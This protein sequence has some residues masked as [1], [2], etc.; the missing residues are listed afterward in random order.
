VTEDGQVGRAV[1]E[2]RGRVVGLDEDQRYAR[3]RGRPRLLQPPGVPAQRRPGVADAYL[4][5]RLRNDPLQVADLLEDPPGLGDDPGAGRGQRD[6][7]GGPLQHPG[8]EG[9]L[10]R[11]DRAGHRRLGDPEDGGRVGERTRVDHR[12][13]GPELAHLHIHTLSV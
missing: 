11:G 5:A 12:D 2:A 1:A 8:A 3:V 4:G 9:P 6:V 10:Q 7:P 13:Q